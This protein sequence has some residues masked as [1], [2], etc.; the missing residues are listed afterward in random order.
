MTSASAVALSTTNSVPGFKAG[1]AVLAGTLLMSFT[2]TPSLFMEFPSLLPT[3]PRTDCGGASSAFT[4]TA[5]G[6]RSDIAHAS[7]SVRTTSDLLGAASEG[8]GLGIVELV[9][10]QLDLLPRL[11]IAR[12]LMPLARH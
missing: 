5:E 4:L 1:D 9:E 7:S 6:E 11:K 12:F 10:T 8:G 3:V 2:L